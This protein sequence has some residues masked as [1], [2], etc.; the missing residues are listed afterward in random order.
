M[1]VSFSS[2]DR[3]WLKSSCI[4]PRPAFEHFLALENL[5]GMTATFKKLEHLLVTCCFSQEC[6]WDSLGCG[7]PRAVQDTPLA[8]NS[9]S[10]LDL[11]FS[12][13]W[14]WDVQYS[15]LQHCVVWRQLDIPK[16]HTAAILS[17]SAAHLAACFLL[18]ILYDPKDGNDMSLWNNGLSL[19]T[20]QHYNSEDCT[21][22]WLVGSDILTELYLLGCIAM[23]STENQP[24]FWSFSYSCSLLHANFLLGLFFDPE[25]GGDMFVWKV[26]WLSKV[27]MALYPRR[28][29]F[30]LSTCLISI[31]EV[32]AQASSNLCTSWA[33][34]YSVLHL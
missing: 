12:Q 5:E 21:L 2:F 14:L 1:D 8:N 34:S 11:R 10:L 17:G 22:L 15:E 18:G 25:N 19:Q 20:T 31:S 7:W 32:E 26:P 3:N 24:T 16:E 4:R 33:L 29:N 13:Y 6:G 30:S 28:Q 27:Y 9:Y 23:Q